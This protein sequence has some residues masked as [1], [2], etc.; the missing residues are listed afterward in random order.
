[1]PKGDEDKRKHKRSRGEEEERKR[2]REV[3]K[4]E[5]EKESGRGEEGRINTICEMLFRSASMSETVSCSLVGWRG[6]GLPLL[7]NAISF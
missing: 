7:L 5:D 2:G 1:M 6:V 3:R 4:R